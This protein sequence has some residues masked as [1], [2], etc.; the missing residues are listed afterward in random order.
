[1][2]NLFDISSLEKMALVSD[3]TIRTIEIMLGENVSESNA[4]FI[5]RGVVRSYA[6][7][8]CYYYRRMKRCFRR[9]RT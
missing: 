1:M 7:S 5:L 6:Y 2:P 3:E 8:Y 4:A 9:K